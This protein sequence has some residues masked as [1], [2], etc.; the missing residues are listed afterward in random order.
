MTT[1]SVIVIRCDFCLRATHV[2]S[3]HQT[4]FGVRNQAR[5]LGWTGD[6]HG[7]DR[8]PSCTRNE[9]TARTRKELAE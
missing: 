2:G 3:S 4:P 8:C 5:T 1:T 7:K 6:T 9:V